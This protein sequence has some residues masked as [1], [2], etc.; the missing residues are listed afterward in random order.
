MADVLD[1]IPVGQS[2]Y[3]DSALR[4]NVISAVFLQVLYLIPH[5]VV[6]SRLT[7]YHNLVQIAELAN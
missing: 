7:L 2:W 4:H 6:E 3:F 1:M 5:V